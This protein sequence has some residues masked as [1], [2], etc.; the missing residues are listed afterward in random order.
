MPGDCGLEKLD[1]H[2]QRMNDIN[3]HLRQF[4]RVLTLM[5]LL[6]MGGSQWGS[7]NVGIRQMTKHMMGPQLQQSAIRLR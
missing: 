5:T 2:Q 4:T 6:I 3:Q 7:D 1:E